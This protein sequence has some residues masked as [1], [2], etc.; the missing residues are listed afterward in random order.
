MTFSAHGVVHDIADPF[1]IVRRTEEKL[2]DF[3][4][5]LV[6]SSIFLALECVA[7]TFVSFYIQQLPY[8]PAGFAIPFLA[9][10][11]IYNLNRKTDEDED[12]INREDRYSFTKRYE[13][14]L[15]RGS[16]LA[17]ILAVAIAALYNL[18][19]ILIT[20]APFLFGILYSVR[21]LPRA[22]S[23]RR[24][25]EIPVMK[26]LVVGISWSVPASLLPVYLCGA[27]PTMRTALTCMLMFSWGFIASTSPDIRDRVGDE[28]SGVRTIPVILGETR[29]IRILSW[30]NVISG[31]LIF[32]AGLILLTPVL[33]LLLAAVPVYSQ[34]CLTLLPRPSLKD[35]VCDILIDGQYIFLGVA[36]LALS[37]MHIFSG[38]FAVWG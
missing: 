2:K 19:V 20:L 14:L 28:R 34:A 37:N 15:F 33:A 32:F 23:F 7:S 30:V 18:S 38:I 36:I 4:D 29:T 5:F 10:F 27:T 26:N 17:I 3:G 21:W 12:A 16:L 11:A 25:K 6:F 24:L 13:A 8:S 22:S 9:T 35:F 1:W 31:A